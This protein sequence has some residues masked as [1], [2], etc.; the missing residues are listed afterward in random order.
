MYPSASHFALIFRSL[1]IGALQIVSLGCSLISFTPLYS[2]ELN[3]PVV[4]SIT[5]LKFVPL[6]VSKCFDSAISKGSIRDT[7]IFSVLHSRAGISNWNR[8]SV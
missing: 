4:V 1:S 8:A 5:Y 3:I 2:I 7:S 6:I